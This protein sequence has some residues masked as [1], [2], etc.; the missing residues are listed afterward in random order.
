MVTMK[1]HNA[2]EPGTSDA[3]GPSQR[4]NLEE[5][6]GPGNVV[7]IPQPSNSSH[8]PLVCF[9]YYHSHSAKTDH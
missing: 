2:S 3:G 7:L 8:D 5:K 4:S 6:Y 9:A 1:E